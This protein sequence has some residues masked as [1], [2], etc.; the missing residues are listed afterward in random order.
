MEQDPI[1]EGKRI[2]SDARPPHG[3]KILIILTPIILILGALLSG[4]FH[5][6]YREQILANTRHSS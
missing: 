2:L 5:I 3:G 4:W 6:G 1:H